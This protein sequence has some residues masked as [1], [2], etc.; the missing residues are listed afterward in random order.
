MLSAPYPFALQ[1][2][3]RLAFV[4]A[5]FAD[6]PA[7]QFAS[8]GR[9]VNFTIPAN[10]TRALF[11]GT[12]TTIA[13]QTGT[14]A[15]NIVLTP[16]FAMQGGFD[17]TPAAPELLTLTVARAAPQLSTAT[18]LNKTLT[19]FTV[20]LK[21]HSTTRGLR[22]LDIQL[23]PRSGENFS[24]TRLTLDVTSAASSW[25]QSAASRDFGGAFQV[26]IPF[27]LQNGNSS[28]DLVRRL[29]SLTITATNESGV[30]SALTV[31]I[32]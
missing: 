9:S 13:L 31:L 10:S 25:F 18:I 1:G 4:S 30:S 27:T 17:L 15:G 28:D 21:G 12:S 29:E 14:L 16:S 7:I 6:D 8:G 11:N 26:A 22:Q 5:V 20:I 2:V 23:T 32:Q 24:T 3:L 19:S